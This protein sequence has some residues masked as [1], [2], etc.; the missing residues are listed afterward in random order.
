MR[1]KRI[2][3]TL[4]AEAYKRLTDLAARD[5]RVIDQQASF[6]LKHLLI[7]DEPLL[8][9]ADQRSSEAAP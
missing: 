7:I 3:V 1:R 5:E 9:S 6:L 8:T 4:P 2:V